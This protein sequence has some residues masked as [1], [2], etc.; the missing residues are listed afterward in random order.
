MVDDAAGADGL[1]ATAVEAQVQVF[2][3][4]LRGLDLA[5]GQAEHELDP[6]AGGLGFVAG[7]GVGRA[8]GQAQAAV[9]AGQAAVVGARV[10]GDRV[11]AGWDD[12]KGGGQMACQG[13]GDSLWSGSKD[14][15]RCSIIRRSTGFVDSK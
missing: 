10:D 5:L 14:A 13:K 1:A 3:H 2:P 9:D 4:R 15:L 11:G 8:G 12:G 6:A 7:L